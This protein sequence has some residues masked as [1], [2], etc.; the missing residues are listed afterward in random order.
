MCVHVLH[1]T[2]PSLIS[3][4]LYTLPKHKQT[5][6]HSDIEK[7]QSGIGDKVAVFLSY[8]STFITG[9]IIA[10]STNWKMALVVS[11]ML[12]LFVIVGAAHAKVVEINIP[13]HLC[14]NDQAHG[15]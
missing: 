8:L 9:Y 14:N 4:H 13:F 5:R 7:V 12:P 6:T 3:S 2:L 10:F 1:R 15:N 11:T